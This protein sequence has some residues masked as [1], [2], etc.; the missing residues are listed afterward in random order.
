MPLVVQVHGGPLSAYVDEY[1]PFVDFLVGHGWAVLRA[2]Q[3]GS[4][5]YGAEF[6][7]ANRNDLGGGDFRDIMSGVDF[8]L[9]TEPIDEQ[10]MAVIGYSYGGELTGL[11][12]L[13]A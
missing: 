1:A 7:A 13:W 3:R 10:R 9:R 11:R 6:A 12:Q 8:V 4:L 5:G 2:N